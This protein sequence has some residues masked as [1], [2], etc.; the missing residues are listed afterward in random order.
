[1]AAKK[2]EEANRPAEN[3]DMMDTLPMPEG[4]FDDAGAGKE[5]GVSRDD[6]EMNEEGDQDL[7]GGEE[8]QG[9]D[10]DCVEDEFIEPETAPFHES[11]PDPYAG[12]GDEGCETTETVPGATRQPGHLRGMKLEDKVDTG[13]GVGGEAKTVAEQPDLEPEDEDSEDDKG[14]AQTTK[15]VHKDP[16]GCL[17]I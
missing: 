1:M 7:E 13:K 17:L 6:K 10:D 5:D 14:E 3:P 11:Q 9:S 2:A 15:G 12:E 4:I 16:L 8:E